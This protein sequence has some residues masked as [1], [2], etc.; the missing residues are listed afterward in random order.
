MVWPINI[1]VK[2]SS[3]LLLFLV[4]SVGCATSNP[5]IY[6]RTVNTD[7]YPTE[8]SRDQYYEEMGRAYS[9]DQQNEKAIESFRLALLHNPK[10]VSAKIGLADE[11]HKAEMNQL[12]ANE[13]SEALEMNPQEADAWLKLG[14][15]Y[16][17][18]QV[19]L[20]AK[21]AFTKALELNPKDEKAKWLL[22]YVA[23]IEKDDGIAKKYLDQ[24][25]QTSENKT[26]LVFEKALLAKRLNQL[27]QYS[28]LIQSAYESDPHDK[29]ICLEVANEFMARAD[30][31]SA[32]IVLSHFSQA[33]DF[34]LDISQALTYASVLSN[35]FEIA[36][37]ELE[38][39]KRI[40]ENPIEIDLKLA[41]VYFLE[42][43]MQ[44]AEQLYQGVLQED[45]SQDQANFYLGQIYVNQDLID[46]A[47]SA[48][49][50]VRPSSPYF[51]ESQV[52]LASEEVKTGNSEKALQRLAKAQSQR[53]EQLS[54]YLAY[55]ELM[56]QEKH[57]KKALRLLKSGIDFFPKSEDL[58]IQAAVAYFQL[59][60]EEDFKN[61][62]DKA[63]AINPENAEIYAYIAE[64]W[65]L[66]KFNPKDIEG[67]AKKALEFNTQNKNIK[68]LLAWALMAQ[69]RSLGSV[70]LFEKFYEE[71][72]SQPFYAEAL[73]KVYK[74]AD[75]SEKA[76]KMSAQ[77]LKLKNQKHL[78]SD[79]V[80]G[81]Q[82]RPAGLTA[83]AP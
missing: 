16:L 50:Q 62:V 7:L 20:K 76:E 38:K 34:D 64:L 26:K 61:S 78:Q 41:H 80:F 58:H 56:I 46:L 65:F 8:M 44:L 77:A 27:D 42:G 68:P 73:S 67:F 51:S 29:K 35:Q 13:L 79:L 70:A 32:W 63:I 17:S 21:Q 45:P 69:D 36:V 10:R 71:N 43:K 9:K 15:L 40:A 75:I 47:K 81:S 59:G 12:A 14:D 37:T 2:Q 72:P 11:Y 1:E 74:A 57:Y 31:D 39:Q 48:F 4:F 24:I 23:R 33:H 28:I 25:A 55:A 19:Y 49:S 5:S 30:F 60:R 66:K 52:W 82:R 22:F 18:A 3:W 54:L 53:P 6:V 83:P